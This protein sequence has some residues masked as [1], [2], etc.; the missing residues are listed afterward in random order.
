[1][2]KKTNLKMQTTK[3]HTIYCLVLTFCIFL[4]G[5]YNPPSP[6]VL[7]ESANIPRVAWVPN[8]EPINIIG[9]AA[10]TA[11]CEGNGTDG[12]WNNPH[13]VKNYIIDA[14]GGDGIS[15]SNTQLFLRI[16]NCT[17]FNATNTLCQGIKLSNC[18]N[19][20]I[21]NNTITNAYF[22]V[23]INNSKNCSVLENTINDTG[24]GI[25]IENF[26]H[27]NTLR[28][29]YI[30]GAVYGICTSES[31]D[32]IINNNQISGC[33]SRAIWLFDST[34]IALQANVMIGSGPHITLLNAGIEGASS[35]LLD[36]SNT[37]DGKPVYYYANQTGLT[38]P[39]FSNAGAII[40]ANCSECT[41]AGMT[42]DGSTTA[43]T[44]LYGK[45]NTIS[46]NQFRRQ[47]NAGLFLQNSSDT[48]ILNNNILNGRQIGIYLYW[49]N[50]DTFIH[51]N[52]IM[53]NDYAGIS[54]VANDTRIEI[55]ENI[56]RDSD[57]GII[58]LNSNNITVTSNTI[59]NHSQFGLLLQTTSGCFI[60]ANTFAGNRGQ[61]NATPASLFNR[62]DNGTDGNYWNDYRF[63]YPSAID[64]GGIWNIPYQINASLNWD[65][66]P[67]TRSPTNTPPILSHPDDVTYRLGETGFGISW[68]IADLT[69]LSLLYYLYQ[70]DA[71]IGTGSWISDTTFIICV[72]GLSAGNHVY[73]LRITDDFGGDVSDEVVVSVSVFPD[74]PWQIVLVAIGAAVA[75]AIGF[76]TYAKNRKRS[77]SFDQPPRSSETLRIVSTIKPNNG[78][79][80]DQGYVLPDKASMEFLQDQSYW[81]TRVP[82]QYPISPKQ[83]AEVEREL[84]VMEPS[85]IKTA[86]EFFYNLRKSFEKDDFKEP[87]AEE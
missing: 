1:M 6:M 50:S 76:T 43:I 64:L 10:L 33:A 58:T 54:A 86:I 2:Q 40:L 63:R 47:L 19:V 85:E 87:P 16:Q 83:Y 62:W 55:N 22:G 60:H 53:N 73:R 34:N 67:L 5:S 3:I 11:Y 29:N 66:F 32:L 56:I 17:I 27:N 41:I 26:S 65:N 80:V 61:A 78:T 38:T 23:G 35:H 31:S 70:D 79:R 12:S 46:S 20:T 49:N 21:F 39:Q 24:R 75:V 8:H 51:G 84:A 4:L 14:N 9:D 77:R 7:E 28:G 48:K 81:N 72:D 30:L 25:Q 15:I 52:L 42:I 18:D 71:L 59:L 57:Y 69:A 36:T 74:F 68:S 45:N 44:L 13:V 82:L 37:V